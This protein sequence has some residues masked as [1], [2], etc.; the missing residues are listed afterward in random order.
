MK[1]LL[2]IT[3]AILFAYC[4]SAQIVNIPDANFKAALVG[5]SAI[6]T[7]MDTEIQVSEANAYTGVINVGGLNISDI[8]GIEA[9]INLTFLECSYNQITNIDRRLD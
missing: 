6:N 7:N 1:K 9:F 8:T 2:L 5:N 4:L 3:T